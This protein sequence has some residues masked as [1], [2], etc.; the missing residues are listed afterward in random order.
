MFDPD[1][2][3]PRP[4][5]NLVYFGACIIAG[6]RLTREKQVNVRV[7]PIRDA[8]EESVEL[9]HDIYSRVFR[10]MPTAMNKVH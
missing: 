2:H 10:K 4:N 6:L 9:A 3:L 8:V 7:I 5:R 1:S